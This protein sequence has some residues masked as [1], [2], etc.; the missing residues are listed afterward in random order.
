[1]R[2]IA[3]R[4]FT[5][6][7][8]VDDDG[9]NLVDAAANPAPTVTV[10]AGDGSVLYNAQAVVHAGVGTYTYVLPPQAKLDALTATLSYTLNGVAA[11][12]WTEVDVIAQR[13]GQMWQMRQ[14][15]QL[16]AL[17][18]YQLNALADEVEDQIREILG[19]P[20]VLE[21][22]RKT[23]DSMR[24]ASGDSL[25]VT[26]TLNALPYGAGGGHMLVPGVKMPVSV[27]SGTING[28]ALDPV[29]DIPKLSAIDGALIW[30]DYRPWI[31]GR[32]SL[33]GSHGE[34]SPAGDLR[35]AA[36]KLVNHYSKTAD[37]PDRAATVTT[38]GA[39]ILFS[40]PTPDRPTGLPEIDAI[41]NRARLSNVI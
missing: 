14:D 28:A 4:P 1:M 32:Y 41:L 21:G 19:Y 15:P 22:F 17:T 23:W 38:E 27:Y 24:G 6:T 13:L 36:R 9:G 5:I 35:R 18:T 37:W 39:T 8:Y 3:G 31:S 12:I 25:F 26:G 16:A 10:T 40:L 7:F 30:S 29:N 20:P 34:P 33:W 2:V 11:S